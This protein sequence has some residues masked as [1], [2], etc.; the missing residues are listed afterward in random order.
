MPRPFPCCFTSSRR[1]ATL[2][3][4][5]LGAVGNAYAATHLIAL[6]WT[7]QTES[8]S[9]WEGSAD[10]WTLDV[11]RILGALICT[12]M[13]IASV[14]CAAGFY[15]TLKRLPAHVRVFRDYSIADLIFVTLSTLMFAF[16]CV[17]PTLRGAVCEELLRQP[18]LMRSLIDA[19]LTIEN[20]DVYFE[21]GV[22][23]VVGIMSV[24]LIC[25]MQFTLLVTDYYSQLVRMGSGAEYDEF[26]GDESTL[27]GQ[28]IYLLPSRDAQP[29]GQPLVYAPLPR[30][31]LA[32]ARQMNA[33]EA[34]LSRP[35]R[36]SHSNSLPHSHTR[37]D[38]RSHSHS[39]RR[40][41]SLSNSRHAHGNIALPIRPGEGLIPDKKQSR[42]PSA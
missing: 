1:T 11:A 35:S 31:S 37:S 17:Q 5:G 3:L 21:R 9:E 40:A 15:G 12:Y 10:I 25:R 16:A 36:H 34:Y 13:T 26:S 32:D 4:A 7:M 2:V 24:L 30:L 20:C 6:W 41:E 38:S 18:E 14:A 29:K 19:G 39:H 27:G 8:E 33:T 42:K 23:G 28:R 22:I